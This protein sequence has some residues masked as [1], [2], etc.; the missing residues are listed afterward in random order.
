MNEVFLNFL[1]WPAMMATLLS[2]WLIASQS[3][4]KRAIGFWIF[5][6]SNILWVAWGIEKKAYALI[7]MQIGLL[8]MNLRGIYKNKSSSK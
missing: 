8:L 2:A 6:L 3:K 7:F 1:Q 5:I 4:S